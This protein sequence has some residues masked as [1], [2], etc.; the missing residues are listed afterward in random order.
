MSVEQWI[1][2]VH[3]ALIARELTIKDV[4][5]TEEDLR[6]FFEQH[7]DRYRLPLR[8]SVSEIVVATEEDADGVIAELR[9]DPDCFAEMARAHSLSPYTKARGGKRPE[10]MPVDRIQSALVREAVID[11]PVGEIGDPVRVQVGGHEQWY[12]L[13]IDDRKPAREG[14]FEED[15]EQITRDYRSVHARQLRDIINEQAEVSD[16]VVLDPR[17]QGLN[18][19]Y[20][21]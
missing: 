5:Y 19:D 8:V 18:A 12:I 7:K 17:F 6:Q 13:R 2:E 16:V 10:D 15:K 3:L 20:G 11:L 14:S 1:D 9:A 4:T 21:P